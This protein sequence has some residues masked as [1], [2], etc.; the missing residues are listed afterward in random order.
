M[1]VPVAKAVSP[2]TLDA[3]EQEP[4]YI[5]DSRVSYARAIVAKTFTGDIEASS[6]VEML[7][8]RVDGEGAGY[9]AVERVTGSVNG[10]SGTFALLHIG[11]MADGETWARWPIVPGSGTGQLAGLSGEAHIV[12]DPDGAHSFVL[13][14]EVT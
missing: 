8:V 10:R 1:V 3:F 7:S 11:T 9:V 5:E 14:Y 13:D 12:V 2:F 4:P 6:T